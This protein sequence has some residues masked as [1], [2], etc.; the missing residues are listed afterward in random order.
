MPLRPGSERRGGAEM[1]GTARVA[2]ARERDVGCGNA[3][4]GPR[5]IRDHE[6][7]PLANQT[8]TSVRGFGYDGVASCLPRGFVP[9]D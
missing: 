9:C 7:L 1:P 8:A 4:R 3:L 6:P 5:E 2:Q